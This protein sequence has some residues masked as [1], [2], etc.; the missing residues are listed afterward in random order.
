MGEKKTKPKFYI[1]SASCLSS[2]EK[3]LQ[4]VKHS[5][6]FT[7]FSWV[8]QIFRLRRGPDVHQIPTNPG[9]MVRP[10]LP[11]KYVTQI[12]EQGED[13]ECVPVSVSVSALHFKNTKRKPCQ[14]QP[15]FLILHNLRVQI[16]RFILFN[17]FKLSFHIEHQRGRRRHSPVHEGETR[18]TLSTCCL[19]Q[20]CSTLHSDITVPSQCI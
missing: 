18:T 13:E 4:N 11:T 12:R 19:D 14:R 5:D 7:R 2:G 17:F 8:I 16:Q 3:R 9:G 6:M 10:N 15:G 20:I 1:F